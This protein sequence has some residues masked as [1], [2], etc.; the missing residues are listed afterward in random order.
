MPQDVFDTC[1]LVLAKAKVESG[2]AGRLHVLTH[3]QNGY[4]NVYVDDFMFLQDIDKVSGDLINSSAGKVSTSSLD[5]AIKE[6]MS[7][8]KN[9]QEKN[10]LKRFFGG[11]LFNNGDADFQRRKELSLLNVKALLKKVGE[12]FR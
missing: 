6:R 2:G 12:S 3:L 1:V 11:A 4:Q 9:M 5:W 10:A 7:L 8:D